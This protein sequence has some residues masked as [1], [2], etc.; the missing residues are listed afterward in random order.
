MAALEHVE[1]NRFISVL[2]TSQH[3]SENALRRDLFCLVMKP[4]A[5]TSTE[6]WNTVK[7]RDKSATRGAYLPSLY[8]WLLS[9]LVSHGDVNSKRTKRDWDSLT[10]SKSGR[11]VVVKI[12]GGITP[13]PGAWKPSRSE[14]ITK[15][16]RSLLPTNVIIDLRIE[17]CHQVNLPCSRADEQLVRMCGGH[18]TVIWSAGGLRES[19][20]S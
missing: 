16:G 13:P 1:I 12:F 3:F 2:R 11:N 8:V 18:K 20:S 7:L 19:W 17:S 14:K 10:R 4:R 6:N 15:P 5:D 9:I